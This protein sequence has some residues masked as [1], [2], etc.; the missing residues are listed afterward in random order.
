[1]NSDADLEFIDTTP[2][3][4]ECSNLAFEQLPR[5]GISH[6][7]IHIYIY[8]GLIFFISPLQRQKCTSGNLAEVLL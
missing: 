1:M 7:K 2:Q 5:E 8:T 3:I 4:A 6:I